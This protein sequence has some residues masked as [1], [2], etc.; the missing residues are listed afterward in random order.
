[1]RMIV[2]LWSTRF[3]F[4]FF[5]YQNKN[6]MQQ[7]NLILNPDSNKY[8]RVFLLNSLISIIILL[9][10]IKQC[11]HG[12]PIPNVGQICGDFQSL[13]WFAYCQLACFMWNTS[14]AVV[15]EQ[16][17]KNCVPAAKSRFKSATSE[18]HGNTKR[19]AAIYKQRPATQ[20][21]N[22]SVQKK[23]KKNQIFICFIFFQLEFF[24]GLV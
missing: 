2:W 15:G 16:F 4:L 6:L 11:K 22:H 7:L 12:K 21:L 18:D 8:I 1:M 14:V 19:L 23:H 20:R 9:F 24:I 5:S 10:P 13:V 3:L 17:R